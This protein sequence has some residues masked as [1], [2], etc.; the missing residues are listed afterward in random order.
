[1]SSYKIKSVHPA[2]ERIEAAHRAGLRNH[3]RKGH[4]GIVLAAQAQ[5]VLDIVEAGIVIGRIRRDRMLQPFEH[6][7]GGVVQNDLLLGRRFL[8]GGRQV[9]VQEF[10]DL[11]FGQCASEAIHRL[12]VHQQDA[13]RDAADAEGLAELLLL[14]G[15]DLHQLETPGIGR[16]DLFKQGAKRLARAAPRRP[17]I[18]Q[19]GR[20]HGSRND[21]LLKIGDGDVDHGVRRIR[22]EAKDF[23]PMPW[24]S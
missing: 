23:K 21:F 13:G 16:L 22:V 17:E 10:L 15:I 19:H 12:A 14:V 2:L 5:E 1:M 11:A 4:L 8:R 20:G 18:N 24:R 9:L 6:G 7:F 3:R